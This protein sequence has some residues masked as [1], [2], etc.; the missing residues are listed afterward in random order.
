[1]AEDDAKAK[2]FLIARATSSF[3]LYF[4]AKL[5]PTALFQ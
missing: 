4:L 1:M 3:V 2:A 5:L